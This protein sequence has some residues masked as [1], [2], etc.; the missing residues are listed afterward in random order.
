M[1]YSMESELTGFTNFG[2]TFKNKKA[3]SL[4]S[5]FCALSTHSPWTQIRAKNINLH[6]IIDLKK[7]DANGKLAQNSF[8]STEFDSNSPLIP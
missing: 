4:T 2:L 1:E 5:S 6:Y 8:E 3:L 7:P